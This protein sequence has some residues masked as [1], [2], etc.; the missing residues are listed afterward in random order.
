MPWPKS[1]PYLEAENIAKGKM[2]DHKN[3][4]LKSA[5]AWLSDLFGF[6]SPEYCKATALLR[7]LVNEVDPR[8][9]YSPEKAATLLRSL[10]IWNEDPRNDTDFIDS[11]LNKTFRKLGYKVYYYT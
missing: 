4:D 2:R 5:S 11:M 3:P 10:I 8:T 9:F 7:S 6:M 1:T